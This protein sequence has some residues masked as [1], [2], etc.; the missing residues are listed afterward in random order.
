MRLAFACQ[1]C[2]Q[3][4]L[5]RFRRH[6]LVGFDYVDRRAGLTQLAR[7]HVA[8]DLRSHQQQAL[9]F[10]ALVKRRYNRFGYLLFRNNADRESMPLDCLPGRGTDGRDLQMRKRRW[11]DLAFRHAL[12]QRFYA[13][14]ASEN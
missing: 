7:N 14:H 10:D 11:I 4:L 13:V 8:R 1:H 9:P 6:G 2:A 3:A 12:E 5:G